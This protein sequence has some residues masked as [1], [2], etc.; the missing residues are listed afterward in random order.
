M[1][2]LV[3]GIHGTPPARQPLLNSQFF[4]SLLE[5]MLIRNEPAFF[6]GQPG[7]RNFNT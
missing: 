4:R 6:A 2:G 3:P 5:T 1:P 7:L